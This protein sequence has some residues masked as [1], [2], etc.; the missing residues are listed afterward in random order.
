MDS[1]GIWETRGSHFHLSSSTVS[2]YTHVLLRYKLQTNENSFCEIIVILPTIMISVYIYSQNILIFRLG[3]A[4]LHFST[5]ICNVRM[6]LCQIAFSG[7]IL[8]SDLIQSCSNWGGDP[9]MHLR[10]ILLHLQTQS[11]P[12]RGQRWALWHSEW[13]NSLHVHHISKWASFQK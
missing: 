5:A 13:H 9:L 1:G 2:I 12:G 3:K 7:G 10:A 11:Q 8:D 6:N 4:I